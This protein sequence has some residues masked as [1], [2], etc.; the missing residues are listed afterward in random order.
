MEN[1]LKLK[2][3]NTSVIVEEVLLENKT[4]FGFDLSNVIDVNETQRKGIVRSIGELC[5]KID[6]ENYTLKEGDEVLFNKH[7][8]TPITI[9]GVKYIMIEYRDMYIRL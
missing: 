2:A 6:A 9:D 7:K 8:N 4:D 3:L 5:P 1:K